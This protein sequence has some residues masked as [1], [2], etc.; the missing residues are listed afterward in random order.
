MRAIVIDA[1]N[2]VV[3]E[4]EFPD[5]EGASLAFMQKAVG[6]YIELATELDNGDTVFVNEE[7]LLKGPQ[8]FFDIGAHQA[9][10]GNGVI[11]NVDQDGNSISAVSP[12]EDIRASVTFMT[13]LEVRAAI[14]AGRW[15]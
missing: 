9:F 14:Q 6:G 10:A 4:E 5:G 13:P 7:G 2:R 15:P 3:R 11:L 1:V 8:Y 12:V